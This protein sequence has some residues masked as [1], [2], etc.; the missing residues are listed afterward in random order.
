MTKQEALYQQEVFILSYLFMHPEEF[1]SCGLTKDD[2]SDFQTSQLFELMHANY[3]FNDYTCVNAHQIIDGMVKN[4]RFNSLLEN[5]E[6]IT[7]VL[8]GKE[9]Y[10]ITKSIFDGYV[11]YSKS[12]NKGSVF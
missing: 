5:D 12:L 3:R 1:K 6:L 11:R 10:L 7:C 2:F 9:E 8:K 4:K